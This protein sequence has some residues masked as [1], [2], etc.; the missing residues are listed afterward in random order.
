MKYDKKDQALKLAVLVEQRISF[1]VDC[2]HLQMML[3]KSFNFDY[4][5]FVASLFRSTPISKTCHVI[6]EAPYSKTFWSHRFQSVY[7]DHVLFRTK[8][9]FFY[10]TFDM[11]RMYRKLSPP[12]ADPPLSLQT[13]LG[14][15]QTVQRNTLT[16]TEDCYTDAEANKVWWRQT[17]ST[18]Q[19][20]CIDSSFIMPMSW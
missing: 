7:V 15:D 16:N 6:Y 5:H 2:E 4:N 14:H 3:W 13:W 11:M 19:L 20:P 18:R 12:W 10:T 17:R 9:G 8:A 1:M